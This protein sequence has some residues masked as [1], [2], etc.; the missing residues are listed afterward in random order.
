MHEWLTATS[1]WL[2]RQNLRD[3][4]NMLKSEITYFFLPI[5]C[6]FWPEAVRQNTF[7]YNLRAFSPVLVFTIW[8]LRAVHVFS[9][10]KKK[11]ATKMCCWFDFRVQSPESSPSSCRTPPLWQQHPHFTN[12]RTQRG[13]RDALLPIH[14]I[15]NSPESSTQSPF[16]L[17]TSAEAA[18]EGSEQQFLKARPEASVQRCFAQP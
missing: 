13:L 9:K 12:L 16:P 11:T 5:P 2:E 10:K 7:T 8:L 18:G 15:T 17:A 6:F 14:L 3:Q 4:S 1:K